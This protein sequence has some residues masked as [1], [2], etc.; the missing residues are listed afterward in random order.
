MIITLPNPDKPTIINPVHSNPVNRPT[1]DCNQVIDWLNHYDN[2]PV[3][4]DWTIKKQTK[5]E[6]D[7]NI[8]GKS[9]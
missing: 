9:I 3:N 2:D 7:V 8:K 4:I 1:T 6:M 5:K